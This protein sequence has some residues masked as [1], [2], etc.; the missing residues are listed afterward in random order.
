MISI[1]L[2]VETEDEIFVDVFTSHTEDN[3]KR[4]SELANYLYETYGS[5]QLVA[6]KIKVSHQPWNPIETKP[7]VGRF[8]AKDSDRNVWS[9]KAISKK[10]FVRIPDW[11]HFKFS[12]VEF[13]GWMEIP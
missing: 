10:S 5:C 7:M 4:C 12:E 2:L 13:I 9:I 6:M 8:L 1:G 3:A 11:T